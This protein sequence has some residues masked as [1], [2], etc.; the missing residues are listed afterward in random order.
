[1]M[2]R[3]MLFASGNVASTDPYWTYVT[4][5]FQPATGESSW[6]DRSSYGRTVTEAGT[7]IR[8]SYGDR[9]GGGSVQCDD[10]ADALLFD[11]AVDFSGT[12]VVEMKIL[13]NA[14][15]F[16]DRPFLASG[17]NGLSLRFQASALLVD[18]DGVGG[19]LSFPWVYT[20]G[21][22]HD[23]AVVRIA[24][25]SNPDQWRVYLDG[26]LAGT[27]TGDFA[28]VPA[29]VR[30]GAGLLANITRCRVTIGAHRGYTGSS[31]PVSAAAWP[32]SGT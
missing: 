16:P 32:T 7:P 15:A 21:V 24:D 6:A 13:T 2:G 12:F 4:H 17:I 29:A 22:L 10:S 9:A 26:A 25:T 19:F 18:R 3:S 23:V 31:I 11:G 27:T 20:A 5:L 14:F 30:L 1:M 8:S 28:F